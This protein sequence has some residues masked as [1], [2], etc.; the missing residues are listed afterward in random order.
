MEELA[1]WA[2]IPYPQTGSR[3]DWSGVPVDL[4]AL[5]PSD[6][7]EMVDTFGG[8]SF[9]GHIWIHSPRGRDEPYDLAS[10]AAER[11]VALALLWEAGEEIPPE[12]DRDSDRLIAWASTGDGEY[13]YWKI[14]SE[15]SLSARREIAIQDYDGSWEFFDL[16][17][18]EF[19]LHWVNGSLD[20]NLISRRFASFGN[21]FLRN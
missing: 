14:R 1:R 13:L 2:N 6:Y 16:P 17:C 21:S 15:G 7:R 9:D 8:G 11:E 19:L 18:T 12:I 20:V 3:V 10:W 5:L 4:L